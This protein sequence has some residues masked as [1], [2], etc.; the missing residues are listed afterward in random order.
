MSIQQELKSMSDPEHAKHSLRFFKTSKGEYGEGDK[1]LGIKV[2]DQRTIAKTNYKEI[3]IDEVLT[4]LQSEIHEHRLT[5]LIML[6]YKFQ[7]ADQTGRE[8]IANFYLK[9]TKHVNNW[10]LVDSS[11]P[12]I[13]GAYL[14][15]HPNKLSLLYK[16]AKSKNLWEKRIA[17][18]STFY[19]I[20]KGDFDDF[21]QIAEML[22]L[23]NHDLIHKAVG[24]GLRE[25]GKRDLQTEMNFL[26]KHYK[27]MPR[28]M[29]RYAIEKFEAK[30][31]KGYL[32]GTRGGLSPYAS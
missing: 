25:V 6:V 20:G 32:G 27:I 11:A 15:E 12:Y 10:D 9:N 14:F 22:L 1:F 23:D 28:T 5:A 7:K 29:L 21:L 18:L 19:F 3:T 24:W 30:V 2:P 17:V 8:K 31:R 4:L 13:L 16:L 26:D